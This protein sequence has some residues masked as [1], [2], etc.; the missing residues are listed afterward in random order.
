MKFEHEITI[1]ASFDLV[2]DTII[3]INNWSQWTPTVEYSSLDG[4]TFSLGS[5]ATIKQPGTPASKWKVTAFS[6]R[7][8][9]TW[10]SAQ[11]GVRMIA[12]HEIR[13]ID[14]SHTINILS[15]ELKGF[16]TF[17][18]WPILK[19]KI[20][21]ILSAENEGLKLYCENQ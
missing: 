4:D 1:N 10:D 8:S 16:L 18:L 3:D 20:E 11:L 5:I 15:L 2:W 6:N 12:S 14:E 17:L 21:N 19:R 9:F 7:D 13:K